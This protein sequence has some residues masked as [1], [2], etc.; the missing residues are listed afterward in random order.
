[1][2][3]PIAVLLTILLLMLSAC[4]NTDSA[5]GPSE[6]KKKGG[7]SA[8]DASQSDDVTE[9]EETDPEETDPK[10]IDAR[11]GY[12]LLSRA[13]LDKDG[14]GV[15]D[16]MEYGNHEDDTD[17][18]G[19]SDYDEIALCG[20]DPLSA[21]ADGNGVP[22][23]DEDPDGDGLTVREEL[24]LG[25]A[26]ACE[27][28][29]RDGL[30]DYEEI[31]RYRSDP[32]KADSDG[33]GA[34]D[35]WETAHG[36]DPVSA[37]KEFT[38]RQECVG[39]DL[40]AV[41]ELT[42]SASAAQSLRIAPLGDTPLINPTIPGYLGNA[43]SFTADGEFGIARLS[44]RMDSVKSASADCRPVIYCFNP[45]TQSLYAYETVIAD[46]LATAQTTH[47]STYVLLDANV[48]ER[49]LEDHREAD[50][51]EGTG[52]DSN[53]DGISDYI[54]RLMCDGV[55]R[56]NTGSLV[57]GEHT[58]EEIQRSDDF[59]GDGIKNGD[60]ISLDVELSLPDGAVPFNGH[61]YKAFD[62]GYVWDDAEA[63]CE[64]IGGYLAAVTSAEENAFVYNLI[65]G[66]AKNVY[67]LGGFL[68]GN[69]WRWN[70]GEGWNYTN[71]G[72][73]KPDNYNDHAEDRVQMYRVSYNSN[74]V[75]SWNDASYNGAGY[76]S[77]FYEMTN[78][79]F[80]CEW[81]SY[82]TAGKGYAFINSSPIYKD[83]D[84]DG[85]FDFE[86]PTPMVANAFRT[87]TDY[88]RNK[89]DGRYSVSL[90]VKQPE[91]GS[92]R[93]VANGDDVGHTFLLIKDPNGEYVYLGFYPAKFEN[94]ASMPYADYALKN[95]VSFGIISTA[96]TF[97]NDETHE[98]DIA[99]TQE[100]TE[101]G[102]HALIEYLN[103]KP[104][105]DYNLQSM[106]CTTWAVNAM[107]EAGTDINSYTSPTSWTFGFAADFS[108]AVLRG[109]YP[110]LPAFYPYGYNPGQT[111]YDLMKNAPVTVMYEKVRIADGSFEYGAVEYTK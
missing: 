50:I 111:G 97:G 27:D 18:D 71:W 45:E 101:D 95:L 76:H 39:K 57:F 69:E 35:G 89:Y 100:I 6:K 107:K 7:T 104:I 103:R 11:P 53:N 38:V 29:D 17:G 59:D 24:A 2:K 46:G 70:T 61:S 110:L 63:Y 73:N 98:W 86:D 12:A 66:G 62:V 30:N 1:M 44:F 93:A 84:A 15:I 64:S 81:G 56:T 49:Y 33:D 75:S 41:A 36:S 78:T 22:D 67:W 43:F 19:L 9:P 102:Y 14:N 85:F 47:F 109:E 60:E 72:N 99:Y 26:P 94:G 21:D 52:I 79:G 5:D 58:Y 90:I 28:T 3:K 51:S 96:G 92:N 16:C 106:N 83:S 48:Y 34:P 4:G 88:V 25:T 8:R 68:S 40:T 82:E 54:T 23:P 37:D 74:P 91:Y 10:E 20:T 108:L 31:N 32:L 80:V 13:A 105:P 87:M 77:T 55:I 42:A 65:S